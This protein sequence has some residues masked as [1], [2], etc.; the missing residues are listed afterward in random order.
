MQKNSS[1][2]QIFVSSGFQFKTSVIFFLYWK[3][4]I[5][6]SFFFLNYSHRL[7]SNIFPKSKMCFN[8]FALKDP[9]QTWGFCLILGTEDGRGRSFFIGQSLLLAGLT[10]AEQKRLWWGQTWG[11]CALSWWAE[12]WLAQDR[13]PRPWTSVCLRWLFSL[14]I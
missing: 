10:D 13:S 3:N 14:W 5:L 2:L 9:E 6:I 11:F 7:F 8:K 12:A 1:C 4:Y